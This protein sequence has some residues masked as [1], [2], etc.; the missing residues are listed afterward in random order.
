[1]QTLHST[2]SFNIYSLLDIW[3]SQ[4]P[5]YDSY[6]KSFLSEIYKV[7]TIGVLFSTILDYVIMRHCLINLIIILLLSSPIYYCLASGKAEFS[8]SFLGLSIVI[9]PWLRY[10]S[11]GPQ[12]LSSNHSYSLYMSMI[13]LAITWSLK[14]SFS[15]CFALLFS[16][17]IM[18]YI[19][20]SSNQYSTAFG[21][22]DHIESTKITNSTIFTGLFLLILV[23]SYYHL[24]IYELWRK[25]QQCEEQIKQLKQ[26]NIELRSNHNTKDKFLLSLSHEFRNPI[27]SS[28][29]NIELALEACRDSAMKKYLVNCKVAIEMLFHLA[30]NLLDASKIDT[31]TLEMNPNPQ[32][33]FVLVEKVWYVVRDQLSKKDLIGEI[34]ID[35]KM[36]HSIKVDSHFFKKIL[37]NLLLN[38]IKFTN[39][40]AIMTMIT[41]LE[42]TEIQEHLFKPTQHFKTHFTSICHSH[43]KKPVLDSPINSSYMVQYETSPSLTIPNET[44]RNLSKL[45]PLYQ[46]PAQVSL[47]TVTEMVQA[48][49]EYVKLTNQ[50]DQSNHSPEH[51]ILRRREPHKQASTAKKGIIKIEVNDSGCGIDP[52]IIESYLFKKFSTGQKATEERLGIGLG[53]WLTKQL[54]HMMGGD[55][56]V[57]SQANEGSQFVILI[58]VEAAH[59]QE[60]RKLSRMNETIYSGYRNVKLRALVVDD[61]KYNREIHVTFLQRC[62]VIVEKEATNGQEVLEIFRSAPPNFY[63]LI[64]MDIEMPLMNGK[65]AAKRI[66]LLEKE[67]RLRPVQIVFATGNCEKSEHEICLDPRGEIRG[68]YFYRKPVTLSSFEEFTTSIKRKKASQEYCLIIERDPEIIDSLQQALQPLNIMAIVAENNNEAL[69]FIPD[70][71]ERIRAIFINVN[72]H[73]LK[74]NEFTQELKKKFSSWLKVE[75]AGYAKKMSAEKQRF[76]LDWIGIKRIVEYPFSEMNINSLLNA[77]SRM[78]SAVF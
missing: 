46:M 36:P 21:S 54:C 29:G 10:F 52:A 19:C 73:E 49:K 24:L 45:I 31:Q 57:F 20:C 74:P 61:D 56:R 47:H 6:S 1:M 26:S 18:R 44:G 78:N 11:E 48:M 30:S 2:S 7:G 25:N 41:W 68:D 35:A 13:I 14:I 22:I 53:L 75:I 60:V 28:L 65:E 40:G 67:R 8:K 71:K 43:F 76:Y 37:L 70:N 62:G 55:I 27:N 32:D 39:R 23:L 4:N 66:R 77:P 59:P 64:L 38:A 16:N 51:G 42:E 9:F 33:P 15:C 5:E 17:E 12:V 34:F 72:N 50:A 58:P 69:R 63:D 3:K